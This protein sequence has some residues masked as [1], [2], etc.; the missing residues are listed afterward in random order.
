MMKKNR[1]GKGLDA[2]LSKGDI[3]SPEEP[4]LSGPTT[5][6]PTLITRNP[7]QPRHYFDESKINELAPSRSANR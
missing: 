5:V 4:M 2:L 3:L 7:D 6:D 1:L